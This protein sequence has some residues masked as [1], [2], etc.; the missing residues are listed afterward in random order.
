MNH[1]V[2]SVGGYVQPLLKDAK[3]VAKSIGKVEVDMGN[4]SCKVPVATDYIA[5]LE[6]TGRIGK[7]RKSAKC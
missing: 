6:S 2:I 1:F 5:K 3:R 4:T 7:K